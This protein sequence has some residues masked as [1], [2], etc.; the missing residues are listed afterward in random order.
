MS[1]AFIFIF[2]EKSW[3]HYQLLKCGYT[4]ASKDTK[5]VIFFYI[6]MAHLPFSGKTKIIAISMNTNHKA[7]TNSTFP[8]SPR[9]LGR[10]GLQTPR[11]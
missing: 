1:K 9:K 8:Q 6:T 5:G 11:K 2:F 10:A 3:R 7:H 4:F